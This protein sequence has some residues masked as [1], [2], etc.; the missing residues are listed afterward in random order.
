[1]PSFGSLFFETLLRLTL[2]PP[3]TAEAGKDAVRAAA[4]R[5]ARFGPPKRIRRDVFIDR[6]DQHRWPVYSV[7]P[8]GMEADKSVIYVH[9]GAYY[10]EINPFHW[11]LIARISAEAHT[12]AIVPIYPLVPW[13]TALEAVEFISQLA[14]DEL[15]ERPA[16][17]V[18][19]CGDSAGGSI[20]L[21]VAMQLRDEGVQL[22]R[23]VLIHPAL[24]LTLSNPELN[25]V[26]RMDP[27]LRSD[28]LR[29]IFEQWRGGLDLTNPIVSPLHG[30]MSGL[31]PMTVISGT[32]DITNPDTRLL[33]AKAREAGVEVDYREGEGLIHPSPALPTREGREARRQIVRALL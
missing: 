29:P 32:R 20:A 23:T 19:I 18:S 1:M 12:C 6:V 14:R 2:K 24:D 13:G 30:M 26:E 11:R 31:G 17:G 33:V 7:K 27:L 16:R 8:V 3:S 25:A 4:L 9:G 10:G 22:R 15:R 28:A 5:P 21:A